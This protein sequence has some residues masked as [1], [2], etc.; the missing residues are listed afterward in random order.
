MT[1]QPGTY[2]LGASGRLTMFEPVSATNPPAG[3]ENWPVAA[4][5][6]ASRLAVLPPAVASK[7]ASD[8]AE[9]VALS[10]RL[11]ERLAAVPADQRAEL[12]A[13]L[14]AEI[15]RAVAAAG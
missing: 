13:G 5:T 1:P 9:I 8:R 15:S 12:L 3:S 7:P 2:L 4:V 11:A 6:E 14:N 10:R